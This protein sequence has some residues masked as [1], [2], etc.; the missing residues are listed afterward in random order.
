MRRIYSIFLIIA[1]P[2]ALFT[3]C[4]GENNIE[5]EALDDFDHALRSHVNDSGQEDSITLNISEPYMEYYQEQDIEVES[6]Y[7]LIHVKRT[8]DLEVIDG[9]GSPIAVDEINQGDIVYLDFD[10]STR[11]GELQDGE[12]TIE[13]DTLVVDERDG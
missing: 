2:L 6:I 8:E 5:S 1:G 9:E 12:T 7:R 13:T 4:S 11:S 3:A 10:L